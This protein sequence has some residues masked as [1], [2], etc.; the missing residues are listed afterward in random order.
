MTEPPTKRQRTAI[1]TYENSLAD[2]YADPY[3]FPHREKLAWRWRDA[4]FPTPARIVERFRAII[5]H[6]LEQFPGTTTT[7]KVDWAYKSIHFK[8]SDGT[9]VTYETWDAIFHATPPT[10]VWG[11]NVT[12]VLWLTLEKVMYN[13]ALSTILLGIQSPKSPVHRFAQH[14]LYDRSL[15]RTIMQLATTP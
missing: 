3:F 9:G 8:F 2:E 7:T 11:K 10:R 1:M 15:W 5:G 14:E 6:T 12:D 13:R 4:N